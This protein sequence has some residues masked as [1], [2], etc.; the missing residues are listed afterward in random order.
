[1][2]ETVLASLEQ[3]QKIA[4][5]NKEISDNLTGRLET[6][7][8]V[9]PQAN[10]LEGVKVNGKALAIVQKMVDIL[11]TTG[12]AD[13]TIQV[14]G[15]DVSVKG[16]AQMAYKAQVSQGDLDQALIAILNEKA[17]K[18]TTLSGYG[19]GDAYT[20]EEVNAKISAVYKPAGSLIFANLPALGESIL[21]NVY[22]VTDAFTTNTSFVEG[23]GSTYPKDTNVVC[24]KMEN[25][26]KWDVLA[27][28]V[29]I[30]GKVDKE[31]GKGLS[32][33]DFTNAYKTKLDGI[34]EGA[35][36]YVHPT[37]HCAGQRTVQDHRGCQ[38]P[39]ERRGGGHE[40]GHHRAG[41]PGAGYH[42]PA[43]VF[44]AGRP[45]EQGRQGQAGQHRPCQRADGHRR[46]GGGPHQGSLR[47]LSRREIS[48][49]LT[50]KS[51]CSRLR[52]SNSC[53][54]SAW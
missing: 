52:S 25:A 29:D 8:K 42:L 40:G 26:Y 49:W 12:A 4:A 24:I 23:A 22:N 39:C 13:G 17:V 54:L 48:K 30:S 20:K 47:R 21:G 46:R 34:A 14:N 11:V 18:S 7:E 6:I 31:I 51:R 32:T 19:I 44:H 15:V 3:L 50:R 37:Y 16:L 2:A 36:K 5:K 53:T 41:H 35:N 33:H 1:M 43:G 9:G 45:Y 10:V 27:G 28:F 38:R